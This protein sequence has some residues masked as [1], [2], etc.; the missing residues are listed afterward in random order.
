[1]PSFSPESLKV[2][3]GTQNKGNSREISGQ[4]PFHFKE[5]AGKSLSRIIAYLFLY[6][7]SFVGAAIRK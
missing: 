4:G 5:F 3:I 7:N 1:M 6:D 2:Q